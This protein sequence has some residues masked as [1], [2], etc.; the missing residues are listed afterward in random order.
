MDVFY[1]WPHLTDTI[2]AAANRHKWFSKAKHTD[3]K[4][5]QRV[6]M[7]SHELHHAPVTAKK[8]P[9]IMPRWEH[10]A[11]L[12]FKHATVVWFAQYQL[13]GGTVEIWGLSNIRW[14]HL[15]HGKCLKTISSTDSS[16]KLGSA[17]STLAQHCTATTTTK[18]RK[19]TTMM[20]MNNAGDWPIN[21]ILL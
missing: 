8:P 3:Q 17:R 16:P 15:L 7:R 4:G 10:T 9:S 6:C 18:K 11:S 13:L 19:N 2:H 1:G 5:T 20:K 21:D 12:S 14:S